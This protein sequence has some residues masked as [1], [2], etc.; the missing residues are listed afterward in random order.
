[1]VFKGGRGTLV[2]RGIQKKFASVQEIW[3]IEKKANM[4]SSVLRSTTFKYL[5]LMSDDLVNGV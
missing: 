1:M 5:F 2:P 4:P 3:R